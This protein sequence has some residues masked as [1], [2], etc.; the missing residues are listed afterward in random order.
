[1]TTS[2]GVAGGWVPFPL[3]LPQPFGPTMAVT[4]E[5]LTTISPL[6]EK[7]LKPI[8]S[9]RLSFNTSTCPSISVFY[10]ITAVLSLLA[11]PRGVTD[12]VHMRYCRLESDRHENF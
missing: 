4:P 7:D 12:W 6:S 9:I 3:P 5:S 10:Q 8:S 11:S 2:R 1:M